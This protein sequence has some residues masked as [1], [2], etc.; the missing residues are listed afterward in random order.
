MSRRANKLTYAEAKRLADQ[1]YVQ[2]DNEDAV[3]FYRQAIE[4]DD[5]TPVNEQRVRILLAQ[6]AGGNNESYS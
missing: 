6:L 5:C 3:L 1:A 2:G 4:A